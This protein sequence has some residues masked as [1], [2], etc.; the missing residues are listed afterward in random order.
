MRYFEFPNK[1][2]T[3]YQGTIT[4]SQNT[5]LDEILEIQKNMNSDGST[6]NVSRILMK[7][8]L[9][10]IS[11]SVQSGLIPASSQYYLN[12]YDA[13]PKELTTSDTLYAYPI[14][15]SWTMGEG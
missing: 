1:D 14:S 15:Q 2:T 6:V 10:Y 7:F 9:S 3:I 8:D 4:S 13:N 5:G 11:S 12:L